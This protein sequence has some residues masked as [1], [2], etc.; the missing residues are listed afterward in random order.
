MRPGMGRGRLCTRLGDELV[1]MTGS[2]AMESAIV[3][4]VYSRLVDFDLQKW[5]PDLDPGFAP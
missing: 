5:H 3:H 2:P 1:G 4:E